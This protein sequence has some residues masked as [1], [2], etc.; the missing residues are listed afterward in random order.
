MTDNRH[1]TRVAS[2][3]TIPKR[4]NKNTALDWM[5]SQE[6]WLHEDTQGHDDVENFILHISFRNSY[7]YCI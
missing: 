1:R 4:K 2:D 6:Q 7:I 5:I 3:L